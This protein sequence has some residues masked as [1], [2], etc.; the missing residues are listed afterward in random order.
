LGLVNLTN[1][2]PAGKGE[3]TRRTLRAC[4]SWWSRLWLK[5]LEA[6]DGYECYPRWPGERMPPPDQ[7]P[8]PRWDV[9]SDDWELAA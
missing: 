7:R 9:Q 6:A 1:L 8:G 3:R 2:K 4:R 5:L